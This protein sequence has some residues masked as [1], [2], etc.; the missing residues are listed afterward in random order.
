MKLDI[1]LRSGTPI[2]IL[3]MARILIQF[4]CSYAPDLIVFFPCDIGIINPSNINV[5]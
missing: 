1:N 5:V 2:M 4:E 3:I